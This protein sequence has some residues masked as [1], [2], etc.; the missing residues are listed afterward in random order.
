MDQRTL[1]LGQQR[2]GAIQVGERTTPVDVG[3]Q[4]AARIGMAR[5][6][7]VD[8]VAGM[9]VDLC[10][11]TCALDHHHVVLGTQCIQRSR[12]LRPH[13]FAA[14]APGHGGQLGTHL[15]HQHD[16][17][18]RV[19]LGLEQ[20][21][22]HAHL[23]LGTGREGLEILGTAD[24]AHHASGARHHTRVVAHVLRL[25][26]R[27]LEAEVAVVAAQRG[28]EPAFAG[29]A[30]GTQHHHTTGQCGSRVFSQ[31]NGRTMRSMMCSSAAAAS[32]QRPVCTGE[33]WMMALRLAVSQ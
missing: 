14:A 4:Q 17:A 13:L 28:G 23:R 27:H 26:R 32:V 16:L 5:H 31:G 8:D 2:P 25:E 15:P 29:A 1:I 12:D 21:R 19:G 6:A 18:V 20:Q 3:H 11:R 7:H 30:G 10:G 33:V 22:V 24:F 9:Q